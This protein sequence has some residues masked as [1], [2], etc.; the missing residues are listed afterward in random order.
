MSLNLSRATPEVGK[1]Y[2][3]NIDDTQRIDLDKPYV[4]L[5]GFHAGWIDF[6]KWQ[7]TIDAYDGV[8]IGNY[9]LYGV[10]QEDNTGI[11]KFLLTSKTS[12]YTEGWGS[13]VSGEFRVGDNVK[14]EKGFLVG[15]NWLWFT[16]VKGMW[17][18]GPLMR[19]VSSDTNIILSPSFDNTTE[20]TTD[21]FRWSETEGYQDS[22]AY[23]SESPGYLEIIG[24]KTIDGAIV[25][26]GSLLYKNSYPFSGNIFIE[27]L[28]YD[29]NDQYLSSSFAAIEPTVHEE[30][31]RFS[32]ILRVDQSIDADKFKLRIVTENFSDPD[33]VVF[34]NWTAYRVFQSA[35]D[36][37]DLPDNLPDGKGVFFDANGIRAFWEYNGVLTKTFELNAANGNVFMAGNLEVKGYVHSGKIYEACSPTNEKTFIVGCGI[38]EFAIYGTTPNYDGINDFYLGRSKFLLSNS[39]ITL[40]E[41]CDKWYWGDA[42]F[43]GEIR[44]GHGICY[45]EANHK[46]YYP[47][48]YDNPNL[49]REDDIA[50]LWY[51]PG[52]PREGAPLERQLP[53][54][55]MKG[56]VLVDGYVHSGPIYK[57]QFKEDEFGNII[58][59]SAVI[60]GCGI[61]QYGVYGIKTNEENGVYKS[62]FSRFLL[63]N[64]TVTFSDFDEYWGDGI[65]EGELRV[66]KGILWDRNTDQLVDK[67]HVPST[68][69]LWFNPERGVDKEPVL[70]VRGKIITIEGSQIDFSTVEL[71]EPEEKAIYNNFQTWGDIDLEVGDYLTNFLRATDPNFTYISNTLVA[72]DEVFGFYLYEQS[73]E[74]AK[75]AFKVDSGG[76]FFVGKWTENAYIYWSQ[77]AKTLKIAGTVLADTGYIHDNFFIGNDNTGIQIYGA[78]DCTPLNTIF[79]TKD[80]ECSP[81]IRSYDYNSSFNEKGWIITNDG[82]A[83]I[84]TLCGTGRDL[85]LATNYYFEYDSISDSYIRKPS[86]RYGGVLITYSTGPTYDSP[87][88]AMYI[89]DSDPNLANSTAGLGIFASGSGTIETA[90]Y[91]F[92]NMPV[93]QIPR[94][95]VSFSNIDNIYLQ[96]GDPDRTKDGTDGIILQKD[97][98]K[99]SFFGKAPQF[100]PT[101]PL[102][103]YTWLGT[104]DPADLRSDLDYIQDTLA[105]LFQYLGSNSSAQPESINLFKY[106]VVQ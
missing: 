39:T 40:S 28:I 41:N 99:L 93:N 78:S 33:Y 87:G 4:L 10:T 22:P 9:G 7:N 15:K 5:N 16:P 56:N 98:G 88:V 43:E 72:S 6:A 65:F 53:S 2:I 17:I 97:G 54:L 13:F 58:W 52:D 1:K 47:L 74:L 86:E 89:H 101:I 102:Q 73:E 29:I 59:V 60:G 38:N 67:N 62:G 12:Q 3:E 105:K 23:V 91:L 11:G 36:S 71:T 49:R 63:A 77:S 30:W 64:Q 45:D 20:F 82:Y 35:T 24:L 25:I 31:K 83:H 106:E 96:T 80:G 18:Q 66:G 92:Y 57:D 34:D 8:G 76:N 90:T 94:A 27:A 32:Y 69:Y 50:Y 95:I 51:F 26:R 79:Y 42:I 46:L 37:N 84:N 70:E 61:N 44:I 81:Y 85:H 75:W 14:E 55:I 100:Q 103:N 48:S 68:S 104:E 21:T 19:S